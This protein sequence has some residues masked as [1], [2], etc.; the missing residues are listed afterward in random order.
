MRRRWEWTHDVLLKDVPRAATVPDRNRAF[1]ILSPRAI[2]VAH[3]AL[4]SPRILHERLRILGRA[5]EAC[6]AARILIHLSDEH[7]ITS[8]DFYAPWT[9]ILRQYHSARLAA[10]FGKKVVAIPVGFASGSS[11][12]GRELE[13][14]ERSH[15]FA[16]VGDLDERKPTR[17]AFVSAFASLS[18][19][20]HV[21]NGTTVGVPWHAQARRMPASLSASTLRSSSFPFIAASQT[22]PVL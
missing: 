11:S 20:L 19:L 1:Q 12:R 7:G 6:E 13:E 15:P 9:L 8:D 14:G 3:V 4:Q 21:T 22:P 2:Y 10:E 5:L 17:R 16:F 18:G